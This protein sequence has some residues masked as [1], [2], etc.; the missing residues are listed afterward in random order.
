MFSKKKE[1]IFMGRGFVYMVD[2]EHSF[3]HVLIQD[4]TH[5][6]NFS[7]E[8][9][10]FAHPGFSSGNGNG[11]FYIPR[12]GDF[13]SVVKISGV[14]YLDKF[15]PVFYSDEFERVREMSRSEKEA[16]FSVFTHRKSQLKK[17][18]SVKGEKVEKIITNYSCGRKKLSSGDVGLFG[19]QGDSGVLVY[20]NNDVQLF[21]SPFC[22]RTYGFLNNSIFDDCDVY[23]ISSVAHFEIYDLRPEVV[24]NIGEARPVLSRQFFFTK[25]KSFQH[26]YYGVYGGY[27]PIGEMVRH[28]G[29]YFTSGRKADPEEMKCV[30][31]S[32]C[33]NYKESFGWDKI[34]KPAENEEDTALSLRAYKSNGDVFDLT[35]GSRTTRDKRSVHVSEE[36]LHL[37]S[38]DIQIISGG[39]AKVG[40]ASE[41]E[42]LGGGIKASLKSG[43]FSIGQGGA[44]R[45][46]GII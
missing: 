13:V 45:A 20:N 3:C 33:R 6:S 32:D 28:E 21:S 17:E 44:V 27:D 42:L 2:A 26:P 30:K 35:V 1:T 41:L 7:L 11:I 34:I 22:T 40:A 31:S 24:L 9:V 19:N 18:D 43:K 5:S 38:N 36:E 29:V 25:E 12:L 46:P 37:S 14:F 15:L 4:S 39:S 16:H 23:G 10:V 8:N